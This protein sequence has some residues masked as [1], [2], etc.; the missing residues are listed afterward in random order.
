VNRQNI[1]SNQKLEPYHKT[2]EIRVFGHSEQRT[3]WHINYRIMAKSYLTTLVGD[4]IEGDYKEWSNFVDGEDGFF[5]GIPLNARRCVVKFD[6]L[7]KSFTEIGRDV[8]E[9][10][11]K[12]RC[13]VRANTGR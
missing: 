10:Y 11:G 7:D 8:G 4:E 12:W 5:Y 3:H 13:G 6:P 2:Y 9:G 1:Q